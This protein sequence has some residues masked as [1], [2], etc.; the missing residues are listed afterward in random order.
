MFNQY[1]M[2]LHE[3][4]GDFEKMAS[5]GS[6]YIVIFLKKQQFFKTVVKIGQMLGH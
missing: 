5:Q 4:E 1:N 3:K 2:L 6:H